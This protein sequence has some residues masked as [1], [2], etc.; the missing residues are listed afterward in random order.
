MYVDLME[1][2]DKNKESE[3]AKNENLGFVKKRN[4]RGLCANKVEIRTVMHKSSYIL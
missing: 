2:A 3:I 1:H 4:E